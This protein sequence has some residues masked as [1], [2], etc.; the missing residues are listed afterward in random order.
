MI[1]KQIMVIFA[2]KHMA[3]GTVVQAM[4][5]RYVLYCKHVG[6]R[7]SIIL[8]KVLYCKMYYKGVKLGL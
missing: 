3:Q 8:Y 5:V 7:I 4:E 1:D 2:C 6:K